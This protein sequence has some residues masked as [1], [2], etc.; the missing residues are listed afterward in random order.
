MGDCLEV[1]ALNPMT[2]INP[3][4]LEG[5]LLELQDLADWVSQLRLL[6][7]MINQRQVYLQQVQIIGPVV[8]EPLSRKTNPTTSQ[9]HLEDFSQLQVS[10]SPKMISR[11]QA[12]LEVQMTT[13]PNLAFSVEM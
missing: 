1:Q 10:F 4:L 11:N 8:L 2:K 6:S 5:F 12:F 7:Q 13:N 9:N 3:N